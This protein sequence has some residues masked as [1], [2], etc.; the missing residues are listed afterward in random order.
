M[1][2][3]KIITTL[4]LISSYAFSQAPAAVWYKGYGGSER[5]QPTSGYKTS[6]GGYIFAG[7]SGS[8][9]GE[10]TQGNMGS[11]D[12]WIVKTNGNGDIIWQKS[13]GGTGQDCRPVIKEAVGGGYWLLG[14]TTSNNNDINGNHGGYDLW[15]AKLDSNGMLQWSKCIGG[16]GD[17]G[18]D[19]GDGISSMSDFGGLVSN[20]NFIDFKL[21][22]DG[23]LTV[24]TYT[25]ST[26]GDASNVQPQ[27]NV[28]LFKLNSNGIIQWTKSYGEVLPMA[29]LQT[30]DGGYIFACTN[31]PYDFHIIKTDGIGNIQWSKSFGGNDK[32]IP[33]D[34]IQNND[35]TFIVVGMS[36]SL[37]GDV[38]GNHGQSDGWMIKLSSQGN[39]IWQKSKGGSEYDDFQS[40]L[41]SNDG[42]Y[43][44]LGTTASY[45]NGD[46]PV[47]ATSCSY[48]FD[49]W[50]IKTDS[51]GSVVWKQC[52]GDGQEYATELID[53]NDNTYTLLGLIPGNSPL[54][55]VSTLGDAYGVIKLGYPTNIVENSFKNQNII[56]PNP[57]NKS[58]NII[59]ESM[60]YF[61]L[62]DINGKLIHSSTNNLIDVSN[63]STGIYFINLYNSD[64]SIIHQEKF[65]KE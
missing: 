35:G 39:L 36:K 52:Y 2:K 40:I 12:F 9:D 59:S 43:I 49:L 11:S 1:K 61:K 7:E 38:S 41:H 5:E 20:S 46:V 18:W 48:C 65:I 50:L 55:S 8:S 21:T 30:I 45:N 27:N 51:L 32:D 23:G 54:F 60:K 14:A 37:N 56:Y 33:T 58:V 64:N 17:D 25:T 57:A 22:S 3:I 4:L 6:D 13:Y 31:Y 19:N 34:I 47:N 24:L 10:I 29:L 42:G 63:I 44:L 26:D 16:S 62:F 28:W 15:L 53:N